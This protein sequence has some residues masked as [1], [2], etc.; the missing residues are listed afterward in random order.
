MEEKIKN[1][2]FEILEEQKNILYYQEKL[3]SDYKFYFNYNKTDTIQKLE[4]HISKYIE[5]MKDNN[6]KIKNIFSDEKRRDEIL[7]KQEEEIENSELKNKDVI[8]AELR[9]ELS[10]V[11]KLLEKN[12]TTIIPK[13]INYEDCYQIFENFKSIYKIFE[14]KKEVI[15]IL[16]NIINKSDKDEKNNFTNLSDKIKED[17]KKRFEKV[18]TDIDIDNKIETFKKYLEDKQNAKYFDSKFSIDVM[19]EDLRIFCDEL[20]EFHKEWNKNYNKFREHDRILTNIYE[21]LS[22][23]VRVYIKI[24]PLIGEQIK[25]KEKTI[26][27]ND[28]SKKITIKCPIDGKMKEQEYGEFYGIYNDG[29]TNKA[30]YTGSI[31]EESK[32][33]DKLK[34]DNIDSIVES[35]DTISPGLY[36]TFKQVED[37]YSIVLF[38]YGL[39]GSGKT[40]SLLGEKGKPGILHYGLANLKDRKTIKV[41]YIFEEYI[42]SFKGNT[43]NLTGKIIKLVNTV[44]KETKKTESALSGGDDETSEFSAEINKFNEKKEQ[45]NLKNINIENINQLTEIIETYRKNKRRIKK[46]PNNPVSSR[47][48]LYMIFEIEFFSGK[49][50]YITIIDT[51]GRESPV[52]IFELF[53]EPKTSLT[54]LLTQEPKDA[55]SSVELYMKDDY[56]EKDEEKDV[57]KNKK[58]N[59]KDKKDEKDIY[60]A[61]D[62]YEMLKEG[63]YINETI[64]HLIYFFN[65]RNYKPT[66]VTKI[67]KMDDYKVNKYFVN[68]PGNITNA[69]KFNAKNTC[70]IINILEFLD[71]LSSNQTLNADNYKPTKFIALVCVRQDIQYCSQ[72]FSSL[73][74]AEK[75]KSS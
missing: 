34:I 46:T 27:T 24:K 55:I 49:T 1:I 13:T 42:D 57:I 74:F 70:K 7:R 37:G 69:D 8:I 4:E 62:V 14:R 44:N 65:K 29:F 6:E 11:K 72:I 32:N 31:T 16:E 9:E 47:S 64:N 28:N 48:H 20:N 43:G 40:F 56:K 51:A 66:N 33:I 73:D 61:S 59:K 68:P 26:F 35:S 45:L 67:T 5:T 36:S 19:P 18:K 17:I 12:E 52:N 21:D 23:A 63:I 53:I 58:K 2:E 30:A 75:I 22:G 50:G 25:Q 3:L 60:E 39:S 41:K 38:G 54:F 15:S 10:R 71:N